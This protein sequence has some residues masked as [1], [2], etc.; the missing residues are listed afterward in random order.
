MISMCIILMLAVAANT[1]PL[2]APLRSQL[3]GDTITSS[4]RIIFKAP[5]ALTLRVLEHTE[6]AGAEILPGKRG[7]KH[8]ARSGWYT[9]E[10]LDAAFAAGAFVQFA[11]IRW[12]FLWEQTSNGP[13]TRCLVET[14]M[15]ALSLRKV[16]YAAV[17]PGKDIPA[18]VIS[19]GGRTI[20]ILAKY[21]Q[22]KVSAVVT[23]KILNP[24]FV[25]T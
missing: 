3:G 15:K 20:R 16:S 22:Y 19:L 18:R 24:A 8:H 21:F 5:I 6:R 25:C 13:V 14:L 11:T 17:Q 4:S 12:Q 23:L 7:I 10:F 2:P 1:A 9:E